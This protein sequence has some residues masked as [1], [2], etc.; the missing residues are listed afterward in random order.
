MCPHAH[1]QARY[2]GNDIRDGVHHGPSLSVHVD[3]PEHGAVHQRSKKKVDMAHQHQP[4][5]HLH[6]GFVVLEVG[7]AYSWRKKKEVVLTSQLRFDHL[8]LCVQQS[9]LSD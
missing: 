2:D 4:Q 8:T 9:I 1:Q 6:Q 3:V 5:P 7:T